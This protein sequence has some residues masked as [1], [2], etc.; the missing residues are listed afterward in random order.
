MLASNSSIVNPTSEQVG[1][2]FMF[3]GLEGIRGRFK[4]FPIFLCRGGSQVL[5]SQS[6]AASKM[7]CLSVR[8]LKK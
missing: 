5:S 4:D 7:L 2:V 6:L 8:T 1:C 3:C